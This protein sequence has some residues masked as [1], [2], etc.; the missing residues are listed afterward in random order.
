MRRWLALALTAMMVTAMTTVAMADDEVPEFDDTVEDQGELADKQLQ[1]A[2]S[3]A[4]YFSAILPAAAIPEDAP[5]DATQEPS[6]ACLVENAEEA[7]TVDDAASALCEVL[8]GL[9]T[10]DERV[11]WGAMYKLLLLSQA[12]DISLT[13]L[14]AEYSDTDEGWGF[15]KAFK[16]LRD[17]DNPDWRGDTPKNL[18]QFKKQER[19]EKSP[20]ERGPK[21]KDR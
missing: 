3:L 11:G 15:G 20:H 17:G 16:E 7:G 1:R 14:L 4:T 21:K 5:D 19:N 9:R 13:E 10:G 8:V 6:A 2:R 18:G 12:K